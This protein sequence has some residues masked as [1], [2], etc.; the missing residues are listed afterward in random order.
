MYVFRF[1]I[2]L[3][4]YDLEDKKETMDGLNSRYLISHETILYLLSIS[5]INWE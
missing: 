5:P 2:S 1:Y 3:L 4:C